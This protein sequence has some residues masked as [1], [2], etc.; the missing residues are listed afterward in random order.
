MIY[1][2][3]NY[4]FPILLILIFV[5]LSHSK[6]VVFDRVTTVQKPVD[7]RVLTKDGFFAAGGQMVDIYLDNILLKKIMSGGDGYGYLKYTPREAGLKA[8][9]ARTMLKIGT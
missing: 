6:V 4:L 8:I 7:I 9:N 3:K 1:C 5:P 2:F